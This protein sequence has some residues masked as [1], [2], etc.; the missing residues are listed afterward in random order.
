MDIRPLHDRIVVRNQMANTIRAGTMLIQDGTRAPESLI[1]SIEPYSAGWS[2]IVKSTAAQ[3][4]KELESAGWTFFYMA[5]EI[6]VRGF[7]FNDQSRTDR[8]VAHVVDAVKRQH[9]NCLEITQIRRRSFWGLPY[10]SVVAHA[11][12]IQKSRRFQ[13]LPSAPASAGHF[14]RR[15]FYD[16][17]PQVKNEHLAA[18]EAVQ[19]GEN[20]GGAQ[21]EP[22]RALSATLPVSSR[23]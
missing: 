11:R 17:I 10:T 2:F 13:D 7:G 12:H 14:S 15:W 4:D 9:C 5:G 18:S 16:R 22:H 21:T 3:L 6:R 19:A 20:K 8:A 23:Y 1:V